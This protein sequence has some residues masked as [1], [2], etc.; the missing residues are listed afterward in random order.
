MNLK[1]FSINFL[2]MYPDDHRCDFIREA[3]TDLSFPWDSEKCDG[4]DYLESVGSDSNC[5]KCYEEVYGMYK[6]CENDKW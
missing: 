5:I 3:V 1:K 2:R 4:I 6:D